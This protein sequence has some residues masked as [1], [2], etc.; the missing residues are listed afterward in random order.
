[1]NSVNHDSGK[2]GTRVALLRE[3]VCVYVYLHVYMVH[4][5]IYTH[6]YIHIDVCTICT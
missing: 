6:I 4:I 3:A 2:L 5:F 1:M